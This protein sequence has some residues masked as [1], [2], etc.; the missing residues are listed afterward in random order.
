LTN[1]LAANL[2]DECFIVWYDR[3]TPGDTDFPEYLYR[4]VKEAEAFLMVHCRAYYASPVA[5]RELELYLDR[6]GETGTS[7]PPLFFIEFERYQRPRAELQTISGYRFWMEH[8]LRHGAG[9]SL[10]LG[11]LAAKKYGGDEDYQLVMVD[12]CYD[13][14]TY[15]ESRVDVARMREEALSPG[16]ARSLDKWREKKKRLQD[17]VNRDDLREFVGYLQFAVMYSLNKDQPVDFSIALKRY[18]HEPEKKDA[19]FDVLAEWVRDTPG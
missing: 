12:L 6:R 4:R 7:A 1:R 13:L 10:T 18:E 19:L 17:E 14:T 15:L 8:P 2:G 3:L 16:V 9:P 11:T 5:Q